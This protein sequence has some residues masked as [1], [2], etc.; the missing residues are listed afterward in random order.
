MK[1]K[2][3]QFSAGPAVLNEI[4][5]SD[6]AKAA[7][8]FQSSGLSLMEMSHRSKPVESLFQETTDLVKNLLNVPSGYHVL[9]LQGGASLQFAMIPMNLLSDDDIADYADTGLWSYKAI[10]ESKKFGHVNISSSSRLSNYN[11]I[12]KTMEQNAQSKYLHITSNNTIYGTQY[13]EMP[14]VL[15]P[16][17][18]LIGDMSSDIFSRPLDLSQFGLIYAG[19]QKNMGPAGITMVIVREDILGKI[20]RDIPSYLDYKVHIE[21]QS[22]FN[23]PPVFSLFVVNR[24]LNFLRAMGGVKEMEKINIRKA[25]FLYA[26]I[27]RNS[28]FTSPITKEDQSLMNVPFVFK[29]GRDE[30]HFLSFCEKRGLMTLKGH[31]SV[32]GFRASIYNAMPVEGV[33]ALVKTMQ[34][35][36]D[37]KG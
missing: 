19:A 21:K 1:R 14:E 16:N 33:M 30:N 7:I 3:Y 31:R 4:V 20:D 15:N 27:E 32:G 2:I 8:D 37:I 6:S 13:K 24:T 36:E 26:E 35:Y 5:L 18:Y 23:T 28:L 22:L 11:Y 29:Q 12:P 17:G 25:G 10:K 9:W 34:D